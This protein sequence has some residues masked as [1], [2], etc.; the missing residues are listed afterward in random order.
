MYV[1][2]CRHMKGYCC[3][4][5]AQF[6][7]LDDIEWVR[8]GAADNQMKPGEAQPGGA[9]F[10]AFIASCDVRRAAAAGNP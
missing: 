9:G 8:N 7:K 1:C 5:L 2:V 4:R 10:I 6:N 3:M